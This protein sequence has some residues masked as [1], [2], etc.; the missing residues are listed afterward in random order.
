M[1]RFARGANR[2]WGRRKGSEQDEEALGLLIHRQISLHAMRS[3][4]LLSAPIS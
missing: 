1:V 3:W 4:Q 2:G